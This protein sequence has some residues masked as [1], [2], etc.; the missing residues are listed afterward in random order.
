M[1]SET[2]Y[3]TK[4]SREIGMTSVAS[5]INLEGRVVLVT[6]GA[7][8][9]GG[10]LSE[11][12]MSC[13]GGTVI[14]IGLQ[15]EKLK[16][17]KGFGPQFIGLKCDLMKPVTK[18]FKAALTEV[19]ERFCK[20][21]AY[22]MNAGAQKI[23]D[24]A[25]AKDL[26]STPVS[27]YRDL[28]QLNALSHLELFQVLHP[29]LKK[30]DA[31]RIVATSSSVVGRN[32]LNIGAYIVSKSDLTNLTALMQNQMKGTNVLVNAYAPPPVQTWLRAD[33]KGTEPLY[34]NAQPEDVIELPLRLISP[35][36]MHDNKMFVYVD[37][38]HDEKDKLFG[39]PY[40]ANERTQYGYDF[41]IRVRSPLNAGGGTKGD[42]LIEH[43]DTT[44][45]RDLARYT[46]VPLITGDRPLRAV[47]KEPP[48]L[49]QIRKNLG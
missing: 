4:L 23:C 34:A 49:R 47:Y 19:C 32:D 20:I 44:N 6:G 28:M 12:I 3:Y 17:F 39:H 9:I 1:T 11:A 15:E 2:A 31:G 35:D 33:Y 42:L 14:A 13:Y 22:V 10:T 30:S 29:Y 48:H 5:S 36:L 46:N 8:G 7:N 26:I 37:K 18:K 43:Y 38:R 41:D 16:K 21:D 25:T 40:Q 45:S 27:E 24:F